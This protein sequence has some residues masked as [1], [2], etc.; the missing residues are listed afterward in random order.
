MMGS[1]CSS[2]AESLGRVGAAGA[3]KPGAPHSP[4]SGGV[5][6]NVAS[7]PSEG[8]KSYGSKLGSEAGPEA[9]AGAETGA[10]VAPTD[11]VTPT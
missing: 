9:G 10:E 4:R 6:K 8:N 5:A 2:E 7:P 11:G 1:P 3:R